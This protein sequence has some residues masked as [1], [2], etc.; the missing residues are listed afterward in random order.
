MKRT[1]LFSLLVT[2]YWLLATSPVLAQPRAYVT[3]EKSDEVTV[4]DTATDKVISTIKVG[5]RPR[6]VLVSPFEE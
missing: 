6:G 5:Q 4:I 3:N 1:L 2:G